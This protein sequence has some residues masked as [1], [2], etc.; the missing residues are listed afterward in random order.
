ME[1]RLATQV[2]LLKEKEK[3]RSGNLRIGLFLRD[4]LEDFGGVAFGSDERPDFLDLAG[5]A[6]DERTADDAHE[7]AAHEL[8]LLPG[9]E[10]PDR[11]VSGVTEQR[12]IEPV[13]FLER[14]K[15][16]DGIGAH[17]KNGDVE[18]VELPFCVTELGRFDG[19]TGSA[20]FGEEKDENALAGEVFE[21]YFMTF[22]AFE[23][24][25]GG[26]GANFEH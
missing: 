16:F 18:P 15:S 5:F 14:S 9:A 26:F 23:A 22:V 21:R 4:D 25:A 1:H 8:F 20:S 7:G 2:E 3:L 19:S 11:F 17:A 13:L 6:D 10:F 12:E 24:K